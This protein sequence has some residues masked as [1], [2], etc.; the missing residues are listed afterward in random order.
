MILKRSSGFSCGFGCAICCAIIGSGT[1]PEGI[2]RPFYAAATIHLPGGARL[3]RIGDS[4]AEGIERPE[5]I[6][7]A[8]GRFVLLHQPFVDQRNLDAPV[9]LPSL[10]AV[11][12]CDRSVLGAAGGDQPVGWDAGVLEEAH[13]RR[14][15]RRRQLPVRRKRFLQPAADRHVVGV[16]DD[17]DRLVVV[18]L[19]R[20]RDLL[21]DLLA[22]V[23]EVG[24]AGVEEQLLRDVDG[25]HALELAHLELAL[26][27]FLVEVR[28]QLVV[29]RL[30]HLLA[31]LE[32][33]A[34]RLERRD[35]LAKAV[36]L[37]RQAVSLLLQARAL[38]FELAHLLLER[39]AARLQRRDLLALLA[40]H[41][42]EIAL[43]D[44][45]CRSQ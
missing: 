39:R 42:V 17:A 11:V 18:A 5:T 31:A 21:Q 23:L 26:L 38:A 37:F 44:T 2:T 3:S 19:E 22:G 1:I 6:A 43:R 14:G 35:L 4:P 13:Y 10:G 9:L 30:G 41:L 40:L 36:L 27:H 28:E 20:V 15:A 12:G 33:R 32:L 29:A 16:A 24:A 34:L 45:A 8:A 25:Q 7:P